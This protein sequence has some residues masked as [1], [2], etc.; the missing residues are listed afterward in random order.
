MNTRWIPKGFHTI[1]IAAAS[2]IEAGC[3]IVMVDSDD[4]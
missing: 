2:P 1:M 4:A 3:I